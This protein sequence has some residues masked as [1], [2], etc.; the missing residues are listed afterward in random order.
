MG[1]T[2]SSPENDFVAVLTAQVEAA[3]AVAHTEITSLN[4]QPEV[5][6]QTGQDPQ[7]VAGWHALQRVV[8]R[9]NAVAEKLG[10]MVAEIDYEAIMAAPDAAYNKLVDW[11]TRAH[12]A[13]EQAKREVWWQQPGMAKLTILRS[14]FKSGADMIRQ[15]R[16]GRTAAPQFEMSTDEEGLRLRR[17]LMAA[18]ALFVLAARPWPIP[19]AQRFIPPEPPKR[20]TLPTFQAAETYDTDDWGDEQPVS[21]PPK[22]TGPQ[23]LLR[24][25][26][27]SAPI[28]PHVARRS[29]SR[30]RI[31][32]FM[33]LLEAAQVPR[34]GRASIFDV[35]QPHEA[36]QREPDAIETEVTL[37][38]TTPPTEQP[39]ELTNKLEKPAR[40]PEEWAKM[41]VHERIAEFLE[42]H[43]GTFF[44][45]EAIV[46]EVYR[47]VKSKQQ[48]PENIVLAHFNPN[49]AHST[50]LQQRWE[51][52]GLTLQ[53]GKIAFSP[54]EEH[55]PEGKKLIHKYIFRLVAAGT[56]RGLNH[57]DGK[58]VH[59][60]RPYK[61]GSGATKIYQ[62]KPAK[63]APASSDAT[64]SES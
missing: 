27:M 49:N 2:G 14:V 22:Y 62:E 9:S 36:V 54:G 31:P 24:Q 25:P 5:L 11:Q 40:F 20:S 43:Q 33:G 12:V 13:R 44:L 28:Q 3:Y 45:V 37:P 16:K 32:D 35:A 41:A 39:A 19:I 51:A 30:V 4:E 57:F 58:A 18:D 46:R 7:S 50:H 34:P 48:R 23:V 29:T 59:W 1:N 6:R 38:S 26:E 21:K 61:F 17:E 15:A 64:T 47:G 60:D 55:N 56:R 8:D 53:R 42:A 63:N 10:G 52:A